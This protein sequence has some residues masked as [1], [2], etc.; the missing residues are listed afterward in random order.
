MPTQIRGP[1]SATFSRR[2][3]DYQHMHRT[4]TGLIFLRSRE[5]YAYAYDV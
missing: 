1:P 4:A 2:N 5:S 3:E